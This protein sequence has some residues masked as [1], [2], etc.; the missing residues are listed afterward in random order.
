MKCIECKNVAPVTALIQGQ[1]SML[2]EGFI[3]CQI[4]KVN[5]GLRWYQSLTYER[6]CN[7]FVRCAE[8][9]IKKR[10]RWNLERRK[11]ILLSADRSYG[12]I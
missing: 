8:D 2:D 9:E 3:L 7:F 5:G 10:V 4:E 11:S 12:K 6:E 1:K